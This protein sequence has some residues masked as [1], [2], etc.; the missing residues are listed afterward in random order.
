MVGGNFPH[1]LSLQSLALD[2][3]ELPSGITGVWVSG[4][5]GRGVLDGSV[6]PRYCHSD[7]YLTLTNIAIAIPLCC[8]D[9]HC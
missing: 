5:P 6:P 9:C 7:D 1:W 2:R 8:Y 3:F 4:L